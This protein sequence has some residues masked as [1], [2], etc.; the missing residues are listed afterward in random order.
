METIGILN[1]SILTE[2]GEYRLKSISTE[3]A[4]ELVENC[5]LDSAIG[6]KA[7]ANIMSVILGTKIEFNRQLFSQKVGQRCLVFK[8]NGRPEEGKILS[9]KEIEDIG[10]SFKILERLS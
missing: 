3:E 7:T 5:I 10:Y 1:T 6:H 8:L 4:R 2:D 9:I